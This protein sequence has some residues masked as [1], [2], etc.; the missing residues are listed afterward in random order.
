MTRGGLWLAAVLL[1]ASPLDARCDEAGG[2]T[3][4]IQDASGRVV[5]VPAKS[6]ATAPERVV[7]VK[8]AAPAARMPAPARAPARAA[9]PARNGVDACRDH[10]D[11]VERWL[12]ARQRVVAAQQ[13]LEASES[14]PLSGMGGYRDARIAAAERQLEKA[15]AQEIE[16]DTGARNLGVPPSCF[17][18]SGVY[19]SDD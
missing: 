2:D 5:V 6:A 8:R 1:I 10:E 17:D 3:V 18:D 16:I 19:A 15:E 13:E 14:I 12:A 11:L 9:A 7:P 4:V